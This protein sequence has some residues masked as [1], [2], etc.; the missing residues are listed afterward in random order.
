MSNES[1]PSK[2]KIRAYFCWPFAVE[3]YNDADLIQACLLKIIH[4]NYTPI[5][6]TPYIVSTKFWSMDLGIIHSTI[7]A[8][9]VIFLFLEEH[10]TEQMM[11]ELLYARTI[12][13]PVVRITDFPKGV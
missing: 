2:R 1:K 7:E 5:L 11:E 9:D 3:K 4:R 8:C 12:G 6:A 10:M 13:K